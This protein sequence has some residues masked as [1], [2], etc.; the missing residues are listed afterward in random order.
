MTA[1]MATSAVPASSTQPKYR[2]SITLCTTCAI[3]RLLD[4]LDALDHVGVLRTVLVPHRLHGILERLLV[5]DFGDGDAGG[6]GLVEGGLLVDR[7]QRAFLELRLAR[8][9]LDQRLIGGRKRIP[10]LL[11]HDHD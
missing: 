10:G 2:A 8:E 3:A 1:E 6:P 5:G 11:R 4:G 9:L 7:P